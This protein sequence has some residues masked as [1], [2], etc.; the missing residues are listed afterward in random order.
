MP[1]YDEVFFTPVHNRL[2]MAINWYLRIY[3]IKKDI[4]EHG[5]G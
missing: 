3:Y 2:L 4:Q 1:I 5:D